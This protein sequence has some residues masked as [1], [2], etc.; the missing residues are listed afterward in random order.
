MEEVVKA[1]RAATQLSGAHIA[2]VLA[3]ELG[4]QP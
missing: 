1:N 2:C 3:R 4:L